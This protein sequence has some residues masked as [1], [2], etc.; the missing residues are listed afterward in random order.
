MCFILLIGL[1]RWYEAY[2]IVTEDTISRNST[3]ALGLEIRRIRPSFFA[4]KLYD[5]FSSMQYFVKE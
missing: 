2:H 3:D 1:L 4:M 5:R